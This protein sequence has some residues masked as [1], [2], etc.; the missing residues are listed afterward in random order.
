MLDSAQSP[1]SASRRGAS[2]KLNLWALETLNKVTSAEEQNKK[3]SNEG[4]IR[5]DGNQYL[6]WG[7]VWGLPLIFGIAL[8]VDIESSIQW[9]FW[10]ITVISSLAV[11]FN[12]TQ[13][14]WAKRRRAAL[15]SKISLELLTA[16]EVQRKQNDEVL[17]R[18][19]VLEER[20]RRMKFPDEQNPEL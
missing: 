8:A 15:D 18:L 2:A 19:R 10:T 5:E 7:I 16:L 14:L 17:R 12:L 1:S 3:H 13:A 20:T 6:A 4:Q 11:F 9:V